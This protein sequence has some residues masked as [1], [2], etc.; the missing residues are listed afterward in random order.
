[1]ADKLMQLTN[2]PKCPV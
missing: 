2:A 1:M